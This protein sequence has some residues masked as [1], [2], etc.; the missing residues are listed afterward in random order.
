MEGLWEWVDCFSSDGDV[1]QRV[2]THTDPLVLVNIYTAQLSS[3]DSAC[4]ESD[5][6]MVKFIVRE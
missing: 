4:R 5:S 3:S 6:L 2:V 1:R